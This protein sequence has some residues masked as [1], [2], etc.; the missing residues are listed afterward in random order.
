VFG[1]GGLVRTD[2]LPHGLHQFEEVVVGVGLTTD[3]IDMNVNF[4]LA[5]GRDLNAARLFRDRVY[6]SNGLEPPTSRLWSNDSRVPGG[7]K[8]SESRVQYLKK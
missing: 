3:E 7:E 5:G 4:T 1:G 2:E 6:R 8:S